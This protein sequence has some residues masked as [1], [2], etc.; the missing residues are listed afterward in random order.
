M[1]LFLLS[2]THSAY[3]LRYQ[4]GGLANS[5]MSL[6]LWGDFQISVQVCI[7]GFRGISQYL[8]QMA[9]NE[10]RGVFL[11]MLKEVI[12]TI[13]D[14]HCISS[15]SS[16]LLAL[17][18][19]TRQPCCLSANNSCCSISSEVTVYITV[20]SFTTMAVTPRP[21]DWTAI[22]QANK[23]QTCNSWKAL[24]N[25]FTHWLWLDSRINH[26]NRRI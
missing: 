11:L 6:P 1:H 5:I 16:W 10:E 12:Y 15:L 22:P 8:N 18:V 9:Q 7:Y 24:E 25:D 21:N 20:N 17:L 19:Q 13:C 26:Q 3:C 2:L 14:F 4:P 23:W